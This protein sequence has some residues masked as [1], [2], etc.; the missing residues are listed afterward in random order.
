MTQNII[1]ALVIIFLMAGAFFWMWKL[2]KWLVIPIQIILFALLITVIIKVFISKDNA[3]RLNN[4]LAKTGIAEVEKRAVS[5]A[6]NALT[7]NNSN[8]EPVEKSK[9]ISQTDIQQENANSATKEDLQISSDVEPQQKQPAKSEKINF[10][11]ML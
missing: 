2:S 8:E 9:P 1:F 6:V 10:V 4:E 11:D 5:G 7:Q 3:E